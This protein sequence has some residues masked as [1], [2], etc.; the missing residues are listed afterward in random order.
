MTGTKIL[1]TITLNNNRP[2]PV[3]VV[4]PFFDYVPDR[5]ESNILYPFFES[6]KSR[7]E[8]SG[9]CALRMLYGFLY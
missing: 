1:K 8:E 5:Q 2:A 4:I 7:N 6:W 9:R 3:L